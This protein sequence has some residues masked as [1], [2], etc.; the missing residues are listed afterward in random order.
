MSENKH[1]SYIDKGLLEAVYKTSKKTIQ[2]YVRE[3]ERYCRYRSAR[4]SVTEGYVLDDR[5]KLIDLYDSCV[6]QDPHL[7]AVLETLESQIIGERYSLGVVNEKGRFVKDIE[8]TKKIQGTQF[9]KILKGIAEAKLYGF[10]LIE[11]LPNINPNT[12]KLSDIN[13]VERRNVLP[14]QKRVVQRQGI[15]APGWDLKSPQYYNNYILINSGSIGLL[16]AAIPS[17]LAKKFTLAN[18]V[19]FGNTYGQPIIHGKTDSDNSADR[20]MLANNIASAAENKIIVTGLN[21]E[22]DI[23]AFTMSN[24]EKVFTS[25]IELSNKE[26]SNLILGS[27]IMAGENQAY[28]GSADTHQDIFRDRIDVYREFIENSMNEEVIPRLVALKYI[29]PG[30]TFKY[31]NR[32]E[33]AN[34]DKIALYSFLTDRYDVAP[35]E[36]EKEFGVVVGKQHFK[37]QPIQNPKKA[38]PLNFLKRGKL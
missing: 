10:T 14:D 11:L 9:I 23:K 22:I 19:N 31:S 25:L 8:E 27:E 24:S 21:D 28:I 26:V 18:F 1:G 35:E 7:A 17:I 38:E 30:L 16:S 3:I 6:Q 2:D 37:N 33:M 13:L 4:S 20:K 34:D 32:K 5:S 36:I 12:G 29:K 15:W